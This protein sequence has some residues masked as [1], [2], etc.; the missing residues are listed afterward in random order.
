MAGRAAPTATDRSGARGCRTRRR[1]RSA[2]SDAPAASGRL[3]PIQAVTPP[4]ARQRPLTDGENLGGEVSWP[5]SLQCGR[6]DALFRLDMGR[7]DYLHPLGG[8]RLD[9][10]SKLLR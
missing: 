2:R 1:A 9:D 3:A 10:D 4:A 5:P 7:A 6:G 8:I